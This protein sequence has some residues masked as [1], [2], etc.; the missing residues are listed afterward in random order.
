MRQFHFSKAWAAELARQN[1][2][3]DDKQAEMAYA[4]QIIL[5]TLIDALLTL[6]FGAFLGVLCG[7]A[8]S[9]MTVAAF[10]HNAGGGHS[11]SPYRCALVT[12]IIF[13]LFA[14]AAHHIIIAAYGYIIMLNS[15][16]IIVGF[17]ALCKYAPASSSKAP[18]PSPGR[19]KILRMYALLVMAFLSSMMIALYK[20]DWIMGKEMGLC[21]ALSILWVSFN[22]SKTG[23]RLWGV[24]D[25][26]N[27]YR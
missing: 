13:P 15:L 23:E 8:F 14:L 11:E 4:I 18:P 20:S 6:A 7:T 2:L 12:M 1:Q 3:N 27:I 19:R 24:I 10:R 21:V 25:G 5:I 9:L 26:I 16:S 17:I 22:L